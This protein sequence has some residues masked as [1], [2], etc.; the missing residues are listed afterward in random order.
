M[1]MASDSGGELGPDAPRRRGGRPTA[2]PPSSFQRKR[3]LLV[4]YE[5]AKR[6]N[7][8]VDRRFGDAEAGMTE[9]ERALLLL[10]AA[11]ERGMRVPQELS[12]AGFGDFAVQAGRSQVLTSMRVDSSLMG[13]KAAELIAGDAD[14]G[15]VSVLVPPELAARGTTAPPPG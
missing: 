14:A 9:S 6:A 12:I 13:R 1:C 8:F 10:Q 2:E 5:A 7:T 3:T 15:P 11:A 4:E